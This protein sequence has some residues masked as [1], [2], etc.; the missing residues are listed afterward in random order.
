MLLANERM[1]REEGSGQNRKR[2]RRSWTSA[3]SGMSTESVSGVDDSEPLSVDHSSEPIA[4]SGVAEPDTRVRAGP[5][6]STPSTRCIVLYLTA[7]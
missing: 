5:E 7:R 6:V 3:S 2:Q 1:S 4:E